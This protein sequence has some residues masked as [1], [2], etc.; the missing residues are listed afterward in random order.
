MID[1][2]DT[3]RLHLRPITAGDVVALYE[4]DQDPEV[5]RYTLHGR[6]STLE[7]V[8]AT[9]RDRI[10]ARW[11]GYEQATGEFVG[12]F[13]LVPHDPGEYEV[14]Y[15]LLRRMWGRGLATEGTRA[16]ID[17]AFETL[18]ATHVWGQTMAVEHAVPGGHGGLRPHPRPHVPPGR[19]RPDPRLG[20]GR[21]R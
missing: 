2:I 11:L 21:G 10:G 4:L 12:W 15:R 17:A 6:P 9:V 18:G 3:D 14:G 1:R 8:E 19:R 5:M 16:L 7:E 20:G 13:G